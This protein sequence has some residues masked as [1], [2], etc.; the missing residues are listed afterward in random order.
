MLKRF[1]LCTLLAAFGLALEAQT[2]TV[3]MRET[4][5]SL[6]AEHVVEIKEGETFQFF[7][8][9]DEHRKNGDLKVFITIDGEETEIWKGSLAALQLVA[10]PATVRFESYEENYILTYR[11]FADEVP[12]LKQPAKLN[13]ITRENGNMLLDYTVTPR[14]TYTLYKSD[15]LKN[16]IPGKEYSSDA[17]SLEI[18][19]GIFTGGGF[20]SYIPPGEFFKL[21]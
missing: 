19:I 1:F 13:R 11:L 20:S 8:F 7:G 17:G 4:H 2:K 6:L 14:R 9:I 16:W 21:E 10:G 12:L 3:L 15:D 5:P 18:E